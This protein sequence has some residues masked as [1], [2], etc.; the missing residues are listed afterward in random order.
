MRTHAV[1]SCTVD[2]TRNVEITTQSEMLEG[3]AAVSLNDTVAYVLLVLSSQAP[4]SQQSLTVGVSDRGCEVLCF[5]VEGC[6]C[7]QL[8]VG[9]FFNRWVRVESGLTRVMSGER[10]RGRRGN[11]VSHYKIVV[12]C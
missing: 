12:Q 8:T 7:R 1:S 9:A 2:R 6:A 10:C 5:K 11:N 3:T 4:L